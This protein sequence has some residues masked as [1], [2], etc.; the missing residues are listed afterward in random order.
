MI[1][2]TGGHKAYALHMAIEEGV[3]HMF[4]VSAIQMHPKS[5]VVCDEDADGG[6]E[7]HKAGAVTGSP[8][9]GDP[10]GETHPDR[11]PIP[12]RGV[13]AGRPLA[14]A[15]VLPGSLPAQGGRPA[16]RPVRFPARSA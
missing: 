2:I 1:L 4:T 16:T 13:S 7:R 3:N 14:S 10:G 5:V 12:Q 8:S 15:S 6:P 11:P 9:Y